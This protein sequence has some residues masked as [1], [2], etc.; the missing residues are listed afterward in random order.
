MSSFCGLPASPRR[1]G[2]VS[3][4]LA[5]KKPLSVRRLAR[6]SFLVRRETSPEDVEGMHHAVGIL[7]STGGMTSHA[8]VVARGWGKCCVAG[9]GELEIDEKNRKVRLGKKTWGPKDSFSLDGST[10]EVM[11]GQISGSTPKMSKHF[12]TLMKWADAKRRMGVRTN[13][14]T[15]EDSKRARSFGAEGIGLT[16]TEH[17]FFDTDRIT[18]MRRMI[19]ATTLKDR[20]KA[21]KKLLPYQRKDFVG[22]FTAM[23]GLPVTVRLLDP[24]LHEFLPNEEKSVKEVAEAIG[25]KA[26]GSSA[27]RVGPP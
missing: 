7:T 26:Q 6:M 9:A 17:M 4:H 3:W 8:A 11:N 10:G 23:K 13:A 18:N 16:R 22:I 24:P 27:T 1:I 25:V 20:E 21:L 19:L 15:P 2:L 5:L 14:D 12:N